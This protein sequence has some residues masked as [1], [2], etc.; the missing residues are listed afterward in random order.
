MGTRSTSMGHLF[1]RDY[2]RELMVTNTANPQSPGISPLSALQKPWQAELVVEGEI[3][4]WPNG[5]YL[6]NG[7]GVWHIQDYNFRHLF[8]GYATLVKFHFENDWSLQRCKGTQEI[9]LL[10]HEFSEV[11]KADNF[12]KD[13]VSLFTVASLTD[14]ANIGVVKLGDGR[15]VGQPCEN[16]KKKIKYLCN[17][18]HLDVLTLLPDLLRSRYLVVKMEPGSNERR[19]VGRNYVVVPE[20]SLRY[21]AKNLV[22]AKPTPLYKF[23][24]KPNSIAF[25]HGVSK[26][27]G[28]IVA[29]VEVPLFVTFHFIN[30]YKVTDNKGHSTA[31]LSC[32]MPGWNLE[33]SR[34]NGWESA[35]EPDEH[36]R[37]MDMCSKYAYASG[38]KRPCNFPN[39]L[40]KLD[41][42]NKK[43]NIW[44]DEGCVPS[45]PFF[46]ARPGATEEDMMS[47]NSYQ[48]LFSLEKILNDTVSSRV[49]IS[50]ISEE[51]RGHM[52]CC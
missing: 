47:S 31:R 44:Y 45:E 7:P 48:T 30:A 13:S 32:Q 25:K 20:M 39:A 2:S 35:L 41:L 9:M 46:V 36:G 22:R 27:S 49:V 34:T 12:F 16:E 18:A 3:P 4:S 42:V 23:E 24:L 11:P 1:K 15:F 43:V 5:T 51:N 52:Q 26:I 6:R 29:S 28:K 8:D 33:G 50:I 21:S 38:A 37:G 40:T 19:V 14:N 17:L 10:Y